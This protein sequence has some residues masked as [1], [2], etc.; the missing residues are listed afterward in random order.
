MS[1]GNQAARRAVRTSTKSDP[2]SATMFAERNDRWLTPLAIVNALGEFDLDPCAA[3][4]HAT[5]AETW[6]P[7]EVG[8]GLAMPWHG[9]VWL[10]P[11][12]GRT[13]RQWVERLAEH[14][15]GIALIPVAPGTKLWQAV[16]FKHAT[17]V[18]FWRHRI[19]FVREDATDTMTS[20]TES[21][22]IAFSEAD[23]EAL[24]SSDLPGHLIRYVPEPSDSGSER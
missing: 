9:R 5:A 21:A 24:A 15:S 14:G 4:G 11:P 12:Y 20:P 13:M 18:H 2:F 17:A 7:E 10:N 16:V 8:D 19:N 6:M 3:P 23:A 1:G 22:L